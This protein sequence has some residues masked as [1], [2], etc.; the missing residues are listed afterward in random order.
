MTPQHVFTQEPFVAKDAL[1]YLLDAMRLNVNIEFFLSRKELTANG[2]SLQNAS[3]AVIR[4]IRIPIV[5][6]HQFDF[7]FK[8]LFFI[9]QLNRYLKGR[10]EI[11][12][13]NL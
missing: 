2:A 1:E 11:L 9:R 5:I 6:N 3:A 12:K 4:T 7:S 13:E 8:I 10:R